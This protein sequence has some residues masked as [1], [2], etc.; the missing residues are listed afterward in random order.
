[1]PMIMRNILPLSAHHTPHGDIRWISTALDRSFQPTTG[2]R[3]P[4]WESDDWRLYRVEGSDE[5]GLAGRGVEP[6]GPDG[7]GLEVARPGTYS[8]SISPSRYWQITAGEGCLRPHGDGDDTVVEAFEGEQR[9][10]V[11]QRFGI[12]AADECSE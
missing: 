11:E 2:S 3:S 7:F 1:M 8:T 10:I 9:I 6:E 5:F 12:G 4:V